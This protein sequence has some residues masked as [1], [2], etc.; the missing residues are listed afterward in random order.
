MSITKLQDL[1]DKEITLT[2]AECGEFH[3][4]GEFHEGIESVDEAISIFK[5]IP[6][7]RMNGIPSI[8][9]NIHT[10]NT[11]SYEDVEIDIV[12]GK[13]I[14]LEMLEYVP[15]ITNEEK[16]VQLIAE[17]MEKLPEFKVRG[18][19]ALWKNCQLDTAV[20][21]S[22]TCPSLENGGVC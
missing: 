18:S 14:D 20:D 11:E 3:E 10:K 17:L 16:A 4:L 21:N 1:N 8:G 13:V 15:D 6:P 5:K 22:L 9:I 12:T 7:A 19:L 2:V